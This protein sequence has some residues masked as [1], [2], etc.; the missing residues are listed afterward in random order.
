MKIK[1]NARTADMICKFTYMARNIF[2]IDGDAK[3]SEYGLK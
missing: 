1:K 3:V 2:K